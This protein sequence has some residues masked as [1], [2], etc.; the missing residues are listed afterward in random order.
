MFRV[1]RITGD[2]MSP[3]YQDGDFVLIGKGF[4]FLSRHKVRDVIVF[5]HQ[6][7]GILIKEIEK[8][9]NEGVYVIGTDK[10]SLDSRRLGP[11]NPAAIE[12][13]VIWHIRRH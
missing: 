7:Y 8:I 5:T 13:R 12:G 4:F 3:E 9:T 6:Q 2:S 1:L 10:N 11:V